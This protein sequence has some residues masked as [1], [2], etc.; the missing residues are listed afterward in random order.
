[1]VWP[2]LIS[3]D[4]TPRML[5]AVTTAGHVSTASALSAPNP[6]ARRIMSLPFLT[7]SNSARHDR[8]GLS[9][10]CRKG[11]CHGAGMDANHNHYATDT[12]TGPRSIRNSKSLR[13]HGVRHQRPNPFPMERYDEEQIDFPESVMHGADRCDDH[14]RCGSV[15]RLQYRHPEVEMLVVAARDNFIFGDKEDRPGSDLVAHTILAQHGGLHDFVNGRRFQAEDPCCRVADD[16]DELHPDRRVSEQRKEYLDDSE[17]L[18]RQRRAIGIV[19]V[20]ISNHFRAKRAAGWKV[21]FDH[22]HAE[23][24]DLTNY[25]NRLV[26]WSFGI[27]NFN[28]D[29]VSSMAQTFI[30][31][32]PSGNAVSRRTFSVRSVA[33]PD[34]FFGHDTQIIPSGSITAR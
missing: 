6:M 31:T 24:P 7:R 22:L 4:V 12:K 26:R 1:M 25:F 21:A 13:H 8:R 18:A 17:P 33:T 27:T 10:S 14:A 19:E 2:I 28:P 34:A 11:T 30:S 16:Q 9:G 29:Q 32:R 15:G 5:A 20:C 23:L 3:V